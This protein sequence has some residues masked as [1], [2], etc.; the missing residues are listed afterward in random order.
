MHRRYFRLDNSTTV[1]VTYD[2]YRPPWDNAGVGI[3]EVTVSK[4]VE[5]RDKLVELKEL[6]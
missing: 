5:T 3:M 2:D 6:P 1:V 4:K